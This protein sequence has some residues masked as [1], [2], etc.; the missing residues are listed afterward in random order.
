MQ[1]IY[2]IQLNRELELTFLDD[3][4]RGADVLRG[5]RGGAAVVGAG[6]R[7]RQEEAGRGIDGDGADGAA[8]QT[9]RRHVRPQ[10]HKQGQS[11][12]L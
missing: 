10:G 8:R 7:E 12:E 3:N 4:C 2:A 1:Y 11:G 9:I 6:H 5:V